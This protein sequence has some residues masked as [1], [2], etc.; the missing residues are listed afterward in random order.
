M[1][2][3]KKTNYKVVSNVYIG[4][5]SIPLDLDN[6]DYYEL[7]DAIGNEFAKL[8]DWRI[9]EGDLIEGVIIKIKAVECDD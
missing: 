5:I 1:M 9:D 2:I 3:T 6:V 7:G 4:S 8:I